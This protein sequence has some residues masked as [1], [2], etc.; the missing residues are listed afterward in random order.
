MQ[1][2][3]RPVRPIFCSV[4][5]VRYFLRQPNSNWA[6]IVMHLLLSCRPRLFL[7]QRHLYHFQLIYGLLAVL[8]G[9]FL[10]CGPFLTACLQPVMIL[11][12]SRLICL[13]YHHSHPNGSTDGRNATSISMGPVHRKGNE[14]YS[15]H[16]RNRLNQKYRPHGGRLIWM[17]ITAK[18]Q[19][20]FW[21]CFEE[22]LSSDQ[23][24]GQWQRSWF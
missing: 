13:G 20:L 22:C 14:L 1:T 7:N 10:G 15:H 11:H 21:L 23:S 9:P 5:S 18:K 4:T 8:C 17:N 3:F 2:S 24:C 6:R 12:H 16:L 19:R